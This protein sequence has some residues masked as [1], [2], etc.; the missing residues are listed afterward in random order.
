[1]KGARAGAAVR[2][3]RP[4]RAGLERWFLPA[5]FVVAAAW[6]L[7]YLNRL[8]SGPLADSL[9]DDARIYWSWSA[10]IAAGHLLGTQ[11]FFLAPLYPYALGVLRWLRIDSLSALRVV[12]GLWGAV[13]VMLLADAARRV[14]GL[15]AALAIAAILACYEMAVFFDGLI[16]GESLLFFLEALLLW[17]VARR[18]GVLERATDA[19]WAGALIGLLAAGRGTFAV[20]LAPAALL[21]PRRPWR[22]SSV[23]ALLG[24]FALV[25][26]P[27]AV[28]N[29]VVAGEW[30]PFTYNSGFNL[31]VGN[32]A[33][34][35]GTY[36]AI[37][38]EERGQPRGIDGGI[39]LD[40]RPTLARSAGRDFTP[41]GSS[42]EWSRR[43][44]RYVAE[45]PGRA[46]GLAL[47]KLTMLWNVREYPQIENVEEYR[48]LAGPLGIPSP[49]GFALLGV[50]ALI[51]AWAAWRGD[52]V[53]R[54]V[55][56]CAI[57]LTVATLPFFVVDRYRHALI[58]A[59]ALLA[60]VAIPKL[61]RAWKEPARRPATMVAL[62]VAMAVVF[63]PL[64]G[65]S[66]AQR[67]ALLSRNLGTRMMQSG[68]AAAAAGRF[69]EAE[70]DFA[71]AVEADPRLDPAWGALIRVQVQRG[72]MAAAEQTFARARAAGLP[73]LPTLA[74]QALFAA[75][76]HDTATSRAALDRIPASS[77]AADPNLATVVEATR[78]IL[79][80]EP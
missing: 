19:A 47:R 36:V 22:A 11:P 41:A 65:P 40:G 48:A 13:A 46:L 57:A 3:R 76:A 2:E 35:T 4:A 21:L 63:L 44:G 8:S 25:A 73:E 29:R 67:A 79:A 56:G 50:L 80:R 61:G 59:A 53:Q 26:A 55:L 74:Y 15:R 7:A 70:Q 5:V 14:A 60:A 1:V 9:Y 42:R 30:I 27:I 34:A 28:H 43:A 23:A 58:P 39:E 66:H 32:H 16:L 54:F 37:T 20:L 69:V 51:G 12:Q 52:A 71:K 68:F 33:R 18:G 72:E 62:L 17:W 49:G 64:P 77:V 38:G 78:Q 31:Y 24:G 75:L 6:R 10:R 45:H